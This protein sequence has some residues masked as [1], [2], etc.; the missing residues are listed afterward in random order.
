MDKV[1]SLNAELESTIRYKD[2]L[3][4]EYDECSKQLERAVKL[5]ESLGGEKGRWGQLAIE[6]KKAYQN[7]TGDILISSGLIAYLGAFTAAFRTSITDEWISETKNKEI[8]SSEAYSLV[9]VLGNP[10]QMRQWNIDGLPS[11][12]FSL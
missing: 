6:L 8:P 5:I 11:D 2:K 3:E 4:K 1:D 10:V 12:N 9:T 7:L